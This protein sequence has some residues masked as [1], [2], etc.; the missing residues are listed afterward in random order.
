M[1][2][3]EEEFKPVAAIVNEEF[4]P[5]NNGQYLN[6]KGPDGEPALKILFS[7]DY[8]ADRDE[9]LYKM[10][11]EKYYKSMGLIRSKI[12]EEEWSLVRNQAFL[13]LY[14]DMVL[15]RNISNKEFSYD[16]FKLCVLRALKQTELHMQKV[17]TPEY[18][19]NNEKRD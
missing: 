1:T 2:T 5:Q 17:Q 12:K 13:A 10:G 11:I 6:G 14:G 15:S 19:A 18:I 8:I 7:Y 4:K 9:V 3:S 16:E